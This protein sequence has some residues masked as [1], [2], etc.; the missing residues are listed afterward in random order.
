MH[1]NNTILIFMYLNILHIFNIYIF[2]VIFLDDIYLLI[3]K[4]RFKETKIMNE[5][6]FIM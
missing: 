4:M 6:Y 2:L 1:Q 3:D 5:Y